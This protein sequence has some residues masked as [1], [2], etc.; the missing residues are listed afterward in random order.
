MNIQEAK[1]YFGPGYWRG[2]NIRFMTTKHIK[3]VINWL[4]DKTV[5]AYDKDLKLVELRTE[6]RIRSLS[7]DQK[8]RN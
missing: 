5:Y 8:Q 4:K 3:Y 1:L 7:N 2:K 6:L